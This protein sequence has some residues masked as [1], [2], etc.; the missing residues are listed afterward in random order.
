[1]ERPRK[2]LF[3]CLFFL[4]DKE[5]EKKQT[6]IIRHVASRRHRDLHFICPTPRRHSTLCLSLVLLSLTSQE[7]TRSTSATARRLEKPK[8]DDQKPIFFLFFFWRE[9]S[10]GLGRKK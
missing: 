5:K 7:A 6:A 8:H 4:S 1:M 9:R 3:F 2:I 10:K